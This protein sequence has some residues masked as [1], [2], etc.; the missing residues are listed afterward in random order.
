MSHIWDWS[1]TSKA[2]CVMNNT[3]I[4]EVTFKSKTAITF[5]GALC[6]ICC[7][8]WTIYRP[9]WNFFP[10]RF[11]WKLIW[12]MMLLAGGKISFSKWIHIVVV[13]VFRHDPTGNFK[14]NWKFWNFWVN[15]IFH[16]LIRSKVGRQGNLQDWWFFWA[17]FWPEI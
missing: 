4:D 9:L 5:N 1:F 17:K 7:C 15:G 14:S 13:C 8:C 16:P 11:W 2:K 6:W 12:K 10:S 3:R